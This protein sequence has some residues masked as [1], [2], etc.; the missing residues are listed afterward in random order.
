MRRGSLPLDSPHDVSPGGP[1]CQ[2]ATNFEGQLDGSSCRE[3]ISLLS[4]TTENSL[5]FQKMRETFQH[6]QE[7]IKDPGSSVDILV[8]QDF[9]LLFDTETSSRLLQ[10]R[11]TLFRPN[12]I[13]DTKQLTS[14]AEMSQLLLSAECPEGSDLH[15]TIFSSCEFRL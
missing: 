4:Q 11:D 7:L 12:V 2:K 8:G 1:K 14:T 9:T 3:A 10:K 15:E 5:I 13:K 6:R